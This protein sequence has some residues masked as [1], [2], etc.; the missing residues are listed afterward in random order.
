MTLIGSIFKSIV[1]TRYLTSLP[2][3]LSHRLKFNVTSLLIGFFTPTLLICSTSL[4]VPCGPLIRGGKADDSPAHLSAE[5]AEILA[6]LQRLDG[7]IEAELRPQRVFFN[8]RRVEAAAAS[9]GIEPLSSNIFKKMTEQQPLKAYVIP[10]VEESLA[11][12]TLIGGI[13]YTNEVSSHN[14]FGLNRVLAAGDLLSI[15]ELKNGNIERV[16]H[17][18]LQSGS[19]VPHVSAATQIPY[20]L[21]REQIAVDRVKVY[22]FS[23][24][25]Q[26]PQLSVLEVNFLTGTVS[27]LL[28]QQYLDG[29]VEFD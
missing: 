24:H 12:A 8:S 11:D 17:F 20:A 6:K 14:A 21:M 19:F 13:I 25:L 2:R 9:A 22:L 29:D 16:L 1:T 3:V 4:A 5:K 27:G 10:V 18:S 28:A 26:V 23:S 7:K 15:E